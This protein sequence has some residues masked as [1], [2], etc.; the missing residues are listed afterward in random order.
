MQ[1]L[2]DPQITYFFIGLG[3]F[4]WYIISLYTVAMQTTISLAMKVVG[5]CIN[6]LCLMFILHTLF[7]SPSIDIGTYTIVGIMLIIWFSYYTFVDASGITSTN[8]YVALFYVIIDVSTFLYI[9]VYLVDNV[10]IPYQLKQYLDKWG[11][12]NDILNMANDL[13]FKTFS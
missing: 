2:T 4:T 10:L 5:E 9:A 6:V 1:R 11:Y 12:I 3:L 8:P 13:V 7:G